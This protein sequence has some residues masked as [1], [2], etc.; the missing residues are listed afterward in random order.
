MALQ[1]TTL[2]TLTR[3]RAPAET[4]RVEIHALDAG[5]YVVRLHHAEGVK[6]L[7][8]DTG[9]ARRF[10][11]TQWVSR[12]LRPLGFTSAVLTHADTQD[13]MINAPMRPVSAEQ[14][15]ASGMRVAFRT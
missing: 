7:V 10:T 11:G 14:R 2:D 1:E 8:D 13:E 12:A 3:E 9:R 6:E 15:L 4:Y 5:W